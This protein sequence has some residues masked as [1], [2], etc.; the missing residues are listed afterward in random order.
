MTSA[1]WTPG[2]GDPTIAGWVTVATY[3]IAALLCW[4]ARAMSIDAERHWWTG[5]FVLMIL[6][7]INKQL[8]IQT[9]FTDVG[10]DMARAQGWYDRHRVVQGF[11]IVGLIVAGLLAAMTLALT[12]G[13]KSRLWAR[14]SM[15]AT[16]ALGVFVLIR[17]TSFHHV[18]EM[19]GLQLGGLRY[20][21]ILE[22]GPLL[23]IALAAWKT[24]AWNE[25]TNR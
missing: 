21:N 25:G 9:L 13:R 11:F 20:N 15:L 19:L 16:C 22:L 4:R 3:A 18:D 1:Q 7:G 23:L 12:I 2:I 6:M 10:R 17:A 24:A 8:D 14:V 5:L